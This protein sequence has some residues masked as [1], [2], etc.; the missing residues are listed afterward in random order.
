V[1]TARVSLVVGLMSLLPHKTYRVTVN[2]LLKLS[3][4]AKIP[5]RQIALV[6]IQ[7]YHHFLT[8]IPLSL[9][10]AS[11]FSPCCD[12]DSATYLY[13]PPPVCVLV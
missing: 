4:T 11:C 2:W 12:K 8:L 1:R 6:C 5:H 13:S 9:V 3:T 7:N 10:E